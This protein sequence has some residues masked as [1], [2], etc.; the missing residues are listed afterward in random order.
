MIKQ[1][2]SKDKNFKL[3]F[4]ISTVMHMA[5]FLL[6]TWWGILFPPDMK[7]KETYYVD[8]VNLPVASPRS[9]SPTQKG[10]DTEAP[11]PPVPVSRMTM[12]EASKK[13]VTAKGKK[14]SDKDKADTSAEEFAKKMAKL[15]GKAESQHED[16]AIERLRRKTSS[17]GKGR[18][19]MPAAGGT[20]AGSSYEAFIKSRLEDALK[21]TILYSTKKPEIMVR[22]VIAVDGRITRQKIERSSGD[23]TFELAVLRAI[24]I[25]SEKFPP[26]PNHKVFEAGF[27]FK[28]QGISNRK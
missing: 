1:Q 25:A 2:A 15:E 19:G 5:V 26:P 22:L 8:V 9:G 4:I 14:A 3:F 24:E 13:A 7:I 23:R 28:P 10:N 6:L 11:S 21:R 27:I 12:P 18:A 16:A 17:S 20:E